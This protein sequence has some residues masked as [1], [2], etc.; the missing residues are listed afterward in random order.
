MH[1]SPHRPSTHSARP[2]LCR[3]LLPVPS[4]L[5]TRPLLSQSRT[6]SG[7]LCHLAVRHCAVCVRAA[8]RRWSVLSARRCSVPLHQQ[9]RA[10]SM[11]CTDPGRCS[12]TSHAA[13]NRNSRHSLFSLLRHSQQQWEWQQVVSSL[14]VCAVCVR[15]CRPVCGVSSARR[16]S[17]SRAMTRS[18][19]RVR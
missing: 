2:P 1:A 13:Y 3:L 5:S 19:S 17:V 18:T 16:T 15:R 11:T 6:D 12:H 8:W 14:T 10:A 9:D 7:R 4:I